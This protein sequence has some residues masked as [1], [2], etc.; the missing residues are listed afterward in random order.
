MIR[1]NCKERWCWS[2]QR[3]EG[4]PNYCGEERRGE[5][6]KQ[7]WMHKYTDTHRH[8]HTVAH[9]TWR[10]LCN[11]SVFNPAMCLLSRHIHIIVPSTYMQTHTHR[12][13]FA[14]CQS[15]FHYPSIIPPFPQ[16]LLFI[17]CS[18]YP[19]TNARARMRTH[20]TIHTHSPL[21]N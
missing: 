16:P 11:C 20:A 3:W 7:I 4:W 21:S 19:Q 17:Y 12:T 6:D 1:Q 14:D 15:L 13:F 18:G 9:M 2:S 10:W 5:L 8:T